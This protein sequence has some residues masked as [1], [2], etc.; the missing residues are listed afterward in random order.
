MTSFTFGP[1]QGIKLAIEPDHEQ[2]YR[3]ALA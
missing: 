1:L 3:G 2:S